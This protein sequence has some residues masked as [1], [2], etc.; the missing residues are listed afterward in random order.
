M[1][2][3]VLA[4]GKVSMT[5]SFHDSAVTVVVFEE[6]HILLGGEDGF[7]LCKIVLTVLLALLHACLMLLLTGLALFGALLLAGLLLFLSE[8]LFVLFVGSLA[9]FL[10]FSVS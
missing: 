2:F 9:I 6:F 7:Y 3:S 10:C 5:F 8:L 1:A 4:F